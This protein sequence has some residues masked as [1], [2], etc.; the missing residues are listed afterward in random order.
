[1]ARYK[2]TTTAFSLFVGFGFKNPFAT[3]HWPPRA[4]GFKGS[5]LVL[6]PLAR[7][8]ALQMLNLI[9]CPFI[10]PLSTI[11]S[12]EVWADF[13]RHCFR[14][15]TV[16]SPGALRPDGDH[17]SCS[18]MSS[19]PQASVKAT[20]NVF[21]STLNCWNSCLYARPVSGTVTQLETS[22]HVSI[23]KCM[24]RYMEWNASMP[25][26]PGSKNLPI[27]APKA[28]MEQKCP[29]NNKLLLQSSSCRQGLTLFRLWASSS[30]HLS[31]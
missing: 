27:K 11:L 9:Q 16:R 1:M 31:S 12:R 28:H 2:N 17:V 20:L 21:L 22:L 18:V 6:Y 15:L 10:H 7:P 29:R 4:T 23:D 26:R 14:L 25:F 8:N 3:K 24:D 13:A 5:W 30:P 19:V